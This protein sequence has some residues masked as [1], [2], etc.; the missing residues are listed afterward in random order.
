M[1]S[2]HDVSIYKEDAYTLKDWLNDNI[3]AYFYERLTVECEYKQA[4]LWKPAEVSWFV[5]SNSIDVELSLNDTHFIP[6]NQYSHN[7]PLGIVRGTHWSL[8]VLHRG[9]FFHFDSLSPYNSKDAHK[10]AQFFTKDF[11]G[12]TEA[13]C[14]RQE[15]GRK[16]KVIIIKEWIVGCT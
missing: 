9:E 7:T 11:K 5:E 14:Q 2:F 6:I 16:F 1:Y 12:I 3:I 8:L 13:Q 10:V 4:R 15:N